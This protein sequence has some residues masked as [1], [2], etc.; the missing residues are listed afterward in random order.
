[1]EASIFCSDN[2]IGTWY[3]T[4]YMAAV[5]YPPNTR[6]TGTFV[7]QVQADSDGHF[8]VFGKAGTEDYYKFFGE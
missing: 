2:S 5:D 4:D 6:K 8:F 3:F 1:M 7:C